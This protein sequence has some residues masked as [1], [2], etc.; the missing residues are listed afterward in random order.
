MAGT[1]QINRV[2]VKVMPS[3][4]PQGKPHKQGTSGSRMGKARQLESQV[5]DL[6]KQ[7]RVQGQLLEAKI[8]HLTYQMNLLSEYLKSI[9]TLESILPNSSADERGE[10][11]ILTPTPVPDDNEKWSDE[12]WTDEDNLA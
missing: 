2:V 10:T 4:R 9:P 11:N 8:A 1:T 12:P 6:R 3:P 5:R 7:I